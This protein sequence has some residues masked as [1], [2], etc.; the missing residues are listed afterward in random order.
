MGMCPVCSCRICSH[1]A[2]ISG[3]SD[4]FP[5]WHSPPRIFIRMPDFKALPFKICHFIP[6][7]NAVR[8]RTLEAVTL[9]ERLWFLLRLHKIEICSAVAFPIQQALFCFRHVP[10]PFGLSGFAC[11]SC[12]SRL[13][14]CSRYRFSSAVKSPECMILSRSRSLLI[15]GIV[16]TS[17][18][19]TAFRAEVIVSIS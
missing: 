17:H 9:A 5:T 7:V 1:S 16:N 6:A 10:S 18:I 19:S 14:S 4:S 12:L 2:G 11:F 15:S 8:E 13:T 3:L